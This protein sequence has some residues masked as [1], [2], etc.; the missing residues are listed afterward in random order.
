VLVLSQAPSVTQQDH[1]AARFADP[2]FA[3]VVIVLGESSSAKW[4]IRA[5]DDGWLRSG[6][7]PDVRYT[8]QT[9]V[10]RAGE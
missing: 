9:A 4:R 6:F 3:W 10:R 2:R 1:L 7:L 5:G 8:E